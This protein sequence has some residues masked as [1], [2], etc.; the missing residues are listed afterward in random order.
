MFRTT[1]TPIIY[2][3]LLISPRKIAIS[4]FVA[5]PSLFEASTISINSLASSSFYPFFSNSGYK[6]LNVAITSLPD[7]LRIKS[8]SF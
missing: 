8:R 2:F 5:T 1:K 6:L 7:N 3:K 4:F